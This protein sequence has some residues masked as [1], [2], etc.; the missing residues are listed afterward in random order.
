MKT[1]AML[2]TLTDEGRKTVKN[3]PERIKLVNKAVEAWGGKIL[4][5]YAL[6]G[7]YDFLSIIQVEDDRAILKISVELGARGS[8]QTITLPAFEIDEFVEDIKT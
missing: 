7:T 3:E 8:L 1:Y 5:Q 6:L 4:C 2:T